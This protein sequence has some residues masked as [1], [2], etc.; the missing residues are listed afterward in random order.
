MSNHAQQRTREGNGGG[1][2]GSLPHGKTWDPLE[3]GN[4]MV[5]AWVDD[6]GSGTARGMTVERG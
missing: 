3:G 1:R 6:G 5:V 4:D 2:G